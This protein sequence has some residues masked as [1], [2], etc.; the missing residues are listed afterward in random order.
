MCVS[1]LCHTFKT[2]EENKLQEKIGVQMN[3]PGPA[4]A[5]DMSTPY[6]ET[7]EDV[8]LY[9]A[10]L[11]HYANLGGVHHMEQDNQVFYVSEYLLFA[12]NLDLTDKP[13]HIRDIFHKCT[14]KYA[15]I[16]S[17]PWFVKL[18]PQVFDKITSVIS[19]EE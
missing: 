11:M 8:E 13:V 5:Y 15:A 9:E 6:E 16:T 18:M 17:T 7:N 10:L 19:K 4:K 14:M 12:K 3:T 2:I 1:T